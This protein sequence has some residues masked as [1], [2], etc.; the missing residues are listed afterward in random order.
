MPV[1]HKHIVTKSVHIANQKAH[2]AAQ[3]FKIARI[4]IALPLSGFNIPTATPSPTTLT[5]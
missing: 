1:Q 5:S 2:I 3:E 4:I